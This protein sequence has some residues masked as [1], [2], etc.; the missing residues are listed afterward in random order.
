M[1]VADSG[2]LKP[3]AEL[4]PTPVLLLKLTDQ[5]MILLCGLAKIS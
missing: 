5:I 3:F 1:T 4:R 2:D